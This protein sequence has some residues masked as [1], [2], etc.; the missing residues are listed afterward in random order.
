MLSRS[1]RRIATDWKSHMG[2]YVYFNAPTWCFKTGFGSRIIPTRRSVEAVPASDRA[3]I[4][5]VLPSALHD[6]DGEAVRK[7]AQEEL[8]EETELKS[9]EKQ[10]HPAPAPQP[11]LASSSAA[12][13]SAADAPAGEEELDMSFLEDMVPQEDLGNEQ[14]Q[15]PPMTTMAIPPSPR[16]SPTSRAHDEGPEEEDHS[17]KKAKVESSKKQRIE[18]V[19][20]T[21]ARM[22]RAVK[23]G[24]DEY[25][26]MDSYDT[27]YSWENEELVDDVWMDEDS[28][29]LIEC[30]KN[31]GQMPRQTRLQDHQNNGL[32]RWLIRLRFPGCLTWAFYKSVMIFMKR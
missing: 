31:F 21:Y 13:F 8:R 4:G 12:P 1:V 18:V 7:K 3:P 11:I 14:P 22:I 6:A 9:M 20:E 16:A 32:T 17:S 25:Y 23:V 29:Q 27:D 28:L 2:F 26:T 19:K 24:T 10:D 15:T 5:P 30:Q